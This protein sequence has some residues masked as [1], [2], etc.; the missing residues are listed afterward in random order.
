M[1][2]QSI[3]CFAGLSAFFR[4]NVVLS[5]QVSL[6]FLD[7]GGAENIHLSEELV[8][9]VDAAIFIDGDA[10]W[11]HVTARS[12]GLAA[13][14]DEHQQPALAVEDLEIAEGGIGNIDVTVRIRGNALGAGKLS[15]FPAHAA[16]G[17]LEV[18]VAI[19]GLNTE[20]AAVRDVDCTVPV[21][22]VT[23]RARLKSPSPLPRVPM[24]F[25]CS[26]VW[27]SKMSRWCSWVSMPPVSIT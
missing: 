11:Q 8:D 20:I 14:A 4:F 25:R 3:S 1:V 15:A 16:K 23:C 27:A 10:G 13:V 26:P 17:Q 6:I 7:A 2:F 24:V 9:N 5:S 18:A 19:K 22:V 21:W 12:R